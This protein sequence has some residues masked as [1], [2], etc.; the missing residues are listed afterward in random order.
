MNSA[1]RCPDTAGLLQE[2]LEG[3]PSAD[4]AH[5]PRCAGRRSEMQTLVSALKPLRAELAPPPAG[6][7]D[8]ELI[9]GLIAGAK[10]AQ[11]DSPA[12]MQALALTRAARA[13]F[14]RD[15]PR[16]RELAERARAI[17]VNLGEGTTPAMRALI[18]MAKA[19]TASVLGNCLINLDHLNE[20]EVLIREALFLFEESGDVLAAGRTR[21]NLTHALVMRRALAEAMECARTAAEELNLIGEPLWTARAR[22]ALAVVLFDLQ[23]QEEAEIQFNAVQSEYGREGLYIERAMVL[24]TL[25]KM[26]LDRKRYIEAS[27]HARHSEALLSWA[28]NR[29]DAARSR[30]LAGSTRLAMGQPAEGLRDLDDAAARLLALGLWIEPALIRCE[31]ATALLGAGDLSSARQ[32]LREIAVIVPA[33][34]DNGWVREAVNALEND[35]ETH[36]ADRLLGTIQLLTNRLKAPA[37]PAASGVLN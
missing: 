7:D 30:W 32:R 2:L 31:Q 13:E 8:S 22:H 18:R 23:R 3:A 20:G 15:W 26:A 21:I 36:S 10:Q 37:S 5:C 4:A 11:A 19:E 29:A 9:A 25:G 1:A 14:Q 34:D 12:A 16:A 24:V 33:D 35:L 17:A 27:E 6:D 28:G